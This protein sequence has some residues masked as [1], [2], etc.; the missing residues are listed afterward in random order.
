MEDDLDDL[1]MDDD[2]IDHMNDDNQGS[3]SNFDLP[4]AASNSTTKDDSV[5]CFRSH[6]GST[7]LFKVITSM[8]MHC[9]YLTCA[10]GV[11]LFLN[12]FKMMQHCVVLLIK[13]HY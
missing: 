7:I 13:V 3:A 6:T 11:L 4:S 10:T 1:D 9:I 8:T 12:T 5:G 2:S